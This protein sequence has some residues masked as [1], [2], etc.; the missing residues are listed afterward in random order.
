MIVVEPHDSRRGRA[1]PGTAA[2][3]HDHRDRRLPNLKELRPGSAGG[4]EVRLLFIFDPQR[5]AVFLVGG[6]NAGKWS[7]WYKAAIPQAEQHT[8]ATLAVRGEEEQSQP[9]LNNAN[10]R[11]WYDLVQEF[12]FSPEEQDAIRS[13]AEEMS[14]RSGRSVSQTCS[15]ASTRL[16]LRWPPPWA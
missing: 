3:G 15:S 4:T 11:Y 6:D 8:R 1:Q 5:R 16:R 10:A 14:P 2:G 13:G 9:P 12:D 7:E